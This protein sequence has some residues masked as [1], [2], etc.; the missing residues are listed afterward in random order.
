MADDTKKSGIPGSAT[1]ATRSSAGADAR[2]TPRPRAPRVAAT[3]STRLARSRVPAAAKAA[4]TAAKP[5]AA[6]P[7][8]KTP[9]AAKK[10][11]PASKVAHVPEPFEAKANKTGKPA[12]VKKTKRVRDTFTMPE[13]EYAL[14]KNLKKRCLDEGVLV[15]KNEILRAAVAGLAKLSDAS[16]LAAVRRLEV[17]HT[18]RKAKRSK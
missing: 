4:T 18:G 6:R 16:V 5:A 12:R 13:P 17:I 15:K 11:P 9:P 1:P 10:S 8:A 14:I 2:P 7:A 3:A